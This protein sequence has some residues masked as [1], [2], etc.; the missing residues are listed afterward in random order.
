VGIS[1]FVEIDKNFFSP[2]LTLC[3]MLGTNTFTDLV[4]SD[5]T[6]NVYPCQPN[7]DD[8]SDHPLSCL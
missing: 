7:L 1:H 2:L 5:E 4:L 6:A 8:T 3:D